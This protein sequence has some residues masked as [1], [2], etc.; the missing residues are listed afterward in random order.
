MSVS[1][2]VS[3][4]RSTATEPAQRLLK[5]GGVTPFTATDFPGKL[6]AVVFAQGC[7]WRCGYCHNPHLQPRPHKSP[8]Q[9]PRVLGL[10]QRRVGLIDGVVFSGGEPTLDPGLAN[11]MRDV[12]K[13]GFDVGLH[14]GG[15]YPRQL[16][17]VLPLLDWVGIDIKAPFDQYES[18]TG[19]PDSGA[20][21]RASLAAVLA[22]GVKYEVR[23]TAHP[24]LLPEESIEQLARELAGM[25]VSNYALQVFRSQ[26]CKDK[27]LNATAMAGY[28]RTELEHKLSLLFPQ[29]TLRRA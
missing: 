6:A 23:T 15:A 27:A 24:T 26:G 29:F 17:E 16:E 7:A 8:L 9:W 21:A 13:L 4:A 28:P 5:V 18:V 2:S 10:L 12:R 25:G 3:S 1:I 11:A 22:S 14:T 19:V 20:P